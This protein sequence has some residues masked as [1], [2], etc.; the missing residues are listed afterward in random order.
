VDSITKNPIEDARA[1]P[2]IGIPLCVDDAGRWRAGRTYHYVHAAYARAIENAG[3]IAVYLPPQRDTRGLVG[4]IDALLVPGGDDLLPP[5]PYP[6]DVLFDPVPDAQLAFDRALLEAALAQEKPVLGICYGMQLL[7]ITLGGALHYDIA[8][9]LPGARSH[10]L[11]EREGRHVLRIEPGTRLAAIAGTSRADVGS[12]HHQSVSEPGRGMRVGARADDGVVE[13]IERSAG[14]FRMGVQWH[15][16]TDAN[17][18]ADALFA[19]F[20]RAAAAGG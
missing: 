2:T 20:I 16:E 8:T 18:L 5:R 6:P 14:G 11:P 19:E 7:A 17:P 10:R 4:R 3:G 13:A 12:R 15:P 1:R 9:D